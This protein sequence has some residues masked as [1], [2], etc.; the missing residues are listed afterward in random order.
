MK[1]TRKPKVDDDENP[2]MLTV[3]DAYLYR[4]LWLKAREDQYK[5]QRFVDLVKES[6]KEQ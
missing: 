6:M 2:D 1:A 3:G 5:W 4:R